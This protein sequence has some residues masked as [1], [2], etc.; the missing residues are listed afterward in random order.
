M[1]NYTDIV[2][3]HEKKQKQTNKIHIVKN[4]NGDTRTA[5]KNVT[6]DQI[7][8]ANKSH[9][10]D[11][12]VV[13][14]WLSVEIAKRAVLHDHTKLTHNDL[15][16]KEIIES[17]TNNEDFT[18]KEFYPMHVNE[19]RHHLFSR[20][21]EDVNLID[22]IEMIVDCTCAGLTRSGEIRDLELN[23]D[24]LNRAVSNT[25]ELIKNNIEVVDDVEDRFNV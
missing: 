2:C 13:M 1:R 10:L 17:I 6:P 22:V 21:P 8:T 24:I 7:K 4:P 9:I 25:I 12:C 18:K 19:E 15:Y 16:C 20:C 11:V 3:D 14:E 5:P 23:N